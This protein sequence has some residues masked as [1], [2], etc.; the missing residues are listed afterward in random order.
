[1]ANDFGGGALGA[2][3]AAAAA[4][5]RGGMMPMTEWALP[6]NQQIEYDHVVHDFEKDERWP[7]IKRFVQGGFWPGCK[8]KYPEANEMYARMMMSS[9]RLAEVESDSVGNALRGV[10]GPGE[11]TRNGAEAVP[12]MDVPGAT[13]GCVNDSYFR[14]RIYLFLCNHGRVNCLDYW[15]GFNS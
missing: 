11:Q 9:R 3:G 15:L 2:G 7:R 4:A 8:V 13:A 6:V 12:Y 1:M 14:Q 5:S 10:P